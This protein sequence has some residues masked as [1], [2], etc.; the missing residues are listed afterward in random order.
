MSLYPPYPIFTAVGFI[1]HTLVFLSCSIP[2][3]IKKRKTN[4][5][6]F[7]G[8]GV[9][10]YA[11]D[12]FAITILFYFFPNNILKTHAFVFISSVLVPMGTVFLFMSAL[13]ISPKLQKLSWA[14]F[15]I[16][17]AF[18]MYSYIHVATDLEK[19]YVPGQSMVHPAYPAVTA[20]NQAYGG[21]SGGVIFGLFF[22][23]H[24]FWS[25]LLVRR[26]AIVIGLGSFLLGLSSYYWISS[27]DALYIASHAIGMIG[28]ITILIGM[29][30][31]DVPNEE[32]NTASGTT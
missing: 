23:Y 29:R 19:V 4:A 26:R 5:V 2:L 13:S 16:G 25:T 32:A 18:I 22:L 10:A 17:F 12:F 6:L 21:I 9:L 20:Q 24:A 11:I 31:M 27:T 30:L 1:I 8:I 15:A 7:L 14:L 28:S 3:L